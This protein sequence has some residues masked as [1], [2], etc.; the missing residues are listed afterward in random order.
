MAQEI[1]TFE[2]IYTAVREELKIQSGD[3][4]SI[5]RIKRNI[6][7][8]Y[9]NEIAPAKRW[10]WLNTS[11]DISIAPYYSTGT[12]TVTADSVTVTLTD[13]PAA[14]RTGY[15]FSVDGQRERYKISSHT[16][17]STT[18]TLQAAYAGET[19]TTAT[20]KIWTD[21]Y[22]LPSTC[23]EVIEVTQDQLTEPLDAYGLQEFRR[24]VNVDPKCEGLPECTFT[25]FDADDELRILK[26]YPAVSADRCTLHV[27]YV[28]TAT[29][30]DATS[31]EPL[32]PRHDRIVL[33]YAALDSSWARERNPEAAARNEGKYARKMAQ[34]M[35][36]KE[37]AMDKPRLVP[38]RNYLATKRR[39][40][41]SGGDF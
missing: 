22:T 39:S 13:A 27:D 38:S 4:E 8:A 3:T 29:A 12:A 14:S 26:Y 31:D 41:R 7:A 25:D 5:N 19:S 33:V 10:P 40:R 18:V 28:Q 34:M 6:N 37:D 32:I 15:W 35:G 1:V 20:F 24:I 9:L 30:L 16:G 2:D 21:S 11:T 17:A 23:R 36:R